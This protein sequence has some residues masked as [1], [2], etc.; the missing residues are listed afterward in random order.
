MV[1][2]P[3]INRFFAAFQFLTVIPVPSFCGKISEKD[4]G[5]SCVFFPLVGLLQGMLLVLFY[6]LFMDVFPVE[7]TAGL[8]I[9]A[10]V[11]SNGGFHLDGLSDTFDALASRKSRERALEIMKDGTAGPIGVASVVLALLLKYL[12]LTSVLGISE[13][14]FYLPLLLFPVQSRWVMV[15]A[16]YLGKSARK[17]GLGKI[18]IEN[19]GVAEFLISLLLAAGTTVIIFIAA[20]RLHPYSIN[21]APALIPVSCVYG[22]GILAVW[23]FRRRFFGLTGDNLGAINEIS[24]VLF[25]L[26]F[27][28]VYS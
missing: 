10:L 16:M 28:G 27:L 24:E 20:G 13:M 6:R 4:V 18:F 15:A 21:G 11:I 12:A 9:T 3:V 14:P 2:C 1:N 7:I 8:L 26:I 5:K 17:D 23:F 19:T 22:F 25:L